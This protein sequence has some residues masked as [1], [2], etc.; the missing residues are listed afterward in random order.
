MSETTLPLAGGDRPAAA[1][2]RA[3]FVRVAWRNLWR[4]RLRT[5]MS[6]VGI[7]FAVLLVSLFTAFQGGTYE[8]WIDAAT[9]LMHGHMQIQHPDY[10]DDPKVTHFVPEGTDL[11]RKVETAPGVSGA[12]PR[13]EAFA[14]V[15]VGERSFGALVVGVDAQREAAMFALP[16]R[17]V[18]GEYLPRSSSAY[19]GSALATNLGVAL[20]DE[21]VALGS[22]REGG[23]AVLA[24]YVDGIFSTGQP[25]LDR[26]IMQVPLGAMQEAFE[27]GD[28]LHR[29]AIKT[30][31]ARRID[32]FLPGVAA[33][34]PDGVRVLDW[35]ELLPEVAQSIEIDDITAQMMYWL[36]MVV[37]AMSVANAF[38]MTV[39]ERTREFGMLLAIGMR[40]NA[41]VGVLVIEAVCIWALGAAIGSA[42]SLA[43]VV[44][45]GEI[46]IDIA[47][48]A[49]G[50][51]EMA[52][53][54]MMPTSIH[55]A[56]TAGSLMLAPAAML[57]G[58]LAA[59]LIPALRVRRMKPVD[60]L[61]EEE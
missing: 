49:E 17:A 25:D 26:S 37:V 34:V 50:M 5:W 7:G 18:Q 59:A 31:D 41:I 10:R 52:A 54:M 14:L 4:R 32:D 12:A 27:L 22:A 39:F 13:T 61:R 23:V 15:S 44:P 42:A 2:T 57:V 55:P 11:V 30:V 58:T 33:L 24:L 6:A 45:L 38:I 16:H 60:A 21:I 35:A 20:G 19:I 36:L 53:Q 40:P 3:L 56:L 51:E 43:V 28:S 46:G 9:G 29:V 8:P 47:R 48:V 1:G